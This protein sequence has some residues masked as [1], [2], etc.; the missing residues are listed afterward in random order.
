MELAA[1]LLSPFDENSQLLLH[2]NNKLPKGLE[3]LVKC[4]TILNFIKGE[5]DL[6][7]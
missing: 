5:G 4:H 7:D 3:Q 1:S 2:N 6:T